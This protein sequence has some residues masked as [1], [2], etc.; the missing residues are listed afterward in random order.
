MKRLSELSV[1][2]T[3]IGGRIRLIAVLGAAFTSIGA[4]DMPDYRG[5]AL[6]L[7][8]LIRDKYAYLDKLPGGV[9]PESKALSAERA[10]ATDR[11]S[12][13]R[14]AEDRM[15][16]LADH[17]AITGSS[18]ADS[19]AVVPTYADLWVVERDG[20]FTIDAVRDGSAAAAAGIR[21]GDRL[22]SVGGIKIKTAV[23]AFWRHLGLDVTPQRAAYAARV[24]AAGRRDRDRQL[25]FQHPGAA[26]QFTTLPS[27]YKD[28]PALPLLTI[29]ASRR[30][31]TIRFNNSLGDNA[32]ITAFDQLVSTIPRDSNLILDLRN[33]PSG[34]N[35][36]VAR[37][38][39]G[40][41]VDHA[42]GY[43]IHNRPEEERS[44]G[45]A[46]QWIEE[47]LPRA[48][49]HRDRV[50]TIL[51]GRWTGSMGE[52]LAIGFAA[53]GASIEGDQMAGLNGSVED[54]QLG[55]TDISVK[56]PTERLMTM[57]GTPREDFQPQPLR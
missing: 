44:T 56:L 3:R 46:H 13:L 21:R 57:M 31:S 45:I 20:T 28:A 12:L 23:T 33:T 37:A 49:K 32:T 48:G 30:S 40:W 55:N 9:L 1:D 11:K 50:P 6:S 54:I 5:A 22:V 17:H 24:L 35:T 7:D 27:L 14:Y 51:V 4:A 18:F 36:T 39:M 8:D 34:G 38:I 52:G 25:G 26:L 43:Q 10:A 19:W 53:L 47:V 41:F 2:L 16:S 42:Q 15:A 29:S